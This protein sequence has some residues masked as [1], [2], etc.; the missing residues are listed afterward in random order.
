M[1]NSFTFYLEHDKIQ[2][3]WR[4]GRA[5][6]DDEDKVIVFAFDVSPQSVLT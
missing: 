4:H 2:S 6:I 1:N 3:Q 5:R